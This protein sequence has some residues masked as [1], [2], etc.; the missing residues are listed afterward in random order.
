MIGFGVP[1]SAAPHD[2]VQKSEVNPT[3]V[4]STGAGLGRVAN[5][6]HVAIW[7]Q[8]DT[9]GE[10]DIYTAPIDA[11]GTFGTPKRLLKLESPF[12]AQPAFSWSTNS[13]GQLALAMSTVSKVDDTYTSNI[14]VWFT[15]DGSR[16]SVPV[17]P[18]PE[19][20]TKD[21]CVQ[22]AG[23][24]GYAQAQ[25]RYGSKDLLALVFAK[26]GA[27]SAYTVQ[28]TSSLDGVSWA[29][30]SIL[31][32]ASLGVSWLESRNQI[33]IDAAGDSIVAQF[34]VYQNPVWKLGATSLD[35][36]AHPSWSALDIRDSAVG[37][38]ET[39]ST[40]TPSGD[41]A[42]FTWAYSS[43]GVSLHYALWN[44]QTQTWGSIQNV[45]T[46]GCQYIEAS[47]S[48]VANFGDQTTIIWAETSANTPTDLKM[49]TLKKDG[50]F[51]AVSL[52]Q[53]AGTG[54]NNVW[55]PY[56]VYAKDGT[57]TIFFIDA[58][59][60]H[61]Y[62]ANV[63]NEALV[64]VQQV[65]QA[66]QWIYSI[67]FIHEAN[68]NISLLYLTQDPVADVFHL[69]YIREDRAS[70]PVASA[71]AAV[72]GTAKVGKALAA[73]AV[74]FSSVSGVGTTTYQWY[75][76]TKQ[77]KAASAGVPSSCKPIKGA[78]KASYKLAK[79]DAKKFILVKLT[80][81]NGVGTTTL[82]SK[83]TAAVK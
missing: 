5:G 74:T 51:N 20:V 36:Q 81:G 28:A 77:V 62:S 50:T 26:V 73:S 14:Y 38:G 11:A 75:S 83:S 58:P 8:A 78:T 6:G 17:Q 19:Y 42:S 44:S 61:I 60:S 24:C 63:V 68:S 32:K 80:N 40:V 33:T 25:V 34:P 29:N 53:V 27:G 69:A 67:D 30:P 76:C 18:V 3:K 55:A 47:S 39:H 2:Y 59:T 31:E 64:D 37:L 7:S 57:Q 35:D 46:C 52:R 65:P 41:L 49:L 10:F 1:A 79:A 82:V 13:K 70:K 16:W 15:T 66:S 48:P 4:Q 54:G 12:M 71:S 23:G 56:N 45:Y 43:E 9:E 22:L 21:G 72:S